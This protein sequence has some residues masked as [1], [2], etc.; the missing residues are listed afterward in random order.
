MIVPLPPPPPS[1]LRRVPPVALY[2]LANL[3][4]IAI[5]AALGLS[6]IEP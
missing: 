5:G 3:I 6:G 1:G 4:A 2:L